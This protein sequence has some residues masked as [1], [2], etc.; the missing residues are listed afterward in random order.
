MNTRAGTGE[1]ILQTH[2]TKFLWR[3]NGWGGGLNPRN[4][5]SGYATVCDVSREIH[6][7][8]CCLSVFT[9]FGR[10]YHTAIVTQ[11]SWNSDVDVELYLQPFQT[12]LL[13]CWNQSVST[14]IPSFKLRFS[15]PL[16]YLLTYFAVHDR[17]DFAAWLQAHFRARQNH[18][19]WRHCITD[20]FKAF[21]ATCTVYYLVAK[22]VVCWVGR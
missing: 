21:G 2:S 18:Y 17:H 19:R 8:K 12:F 3:F 4:P 6:T 1:Y 16:T 13:G 9:T 5:P 22:L 14:W 15:T 7:R 11:R 20:N 10:S